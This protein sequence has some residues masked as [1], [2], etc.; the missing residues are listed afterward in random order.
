MQ[1]PYFTTPDNYSRYNEDIKKFDGYC[2]LCSKPIK[3]KHLY[4]PRCIKKLKK[5]GQEENRVTI[6]VVGRSTI[7]YQ[8]YLHRSFFGCNVHIDYRGAK[9]ERLTAR[10]SKELVIS[11]SKRL[12]A[13]LMKH[14]NEHKQHYIQIRDIRNISRRLLYNITLYYIA[15]HIDGSK[16]FKSYV[17]FQASM[18]QNLLINIE[19]TVIRTNK[20]TFVFHRARGNYPL[21][22]YYDLFSQ[23]NKI[24]TPILKEMVESIED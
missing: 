10:V 1:E 2:R 7:P 18:M 13:L 9:E 6:G 3:Y 21:R 15:Y 16:D 24:V 8:Q 11:Q 22:Y 5:S 12:D 19:N 17:H 23:I 14:N 4:C 20:E